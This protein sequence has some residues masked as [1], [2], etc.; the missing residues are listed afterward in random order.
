MAGTLGA[1]RFYA[2]ARHGARA[3]HTRT[4]T[5]RRG[6][7]G[8]ARTGC[9]AAAAPSS[10]AAT[11]AP[12]RASPRGSGAERTR[13]RG[14]GRP[15]AGAPG[16]GF[17]IWGPGSG[18]R[19]GAA[20]ALGAGASAARLLA[21]PPAA[22]APASP[23]ARGPPRCP[24]PPSPALPGEPRASLSSRAPSSANR[25]H[26]E[27][28]SA[29]GP[30]PAAAGRSALGRENGAAGRDG[31][32]GSAPASGWGKHR[33]PLCPQ[34]PRRDAPRKTPLWR[35]SGEGPGAVFSFPTPVPGPDRPA[36][37]CEQRPVPSAV[38]RLSRAGL[39]RIR[40]LR[41]PGCL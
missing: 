28:P 4:H 32:R 7:S 12:R 9:G 24:R 2:C 19:S 40:R 6:G 22:R 27:P 14:P 39:I 5:A 41:P 36:P 26:R 15:G 3:R 23:A 11:T 37:L 34:Q 30:L 29:A 31:A 21:R 35:P 13:P 10:G 17:R 33:R 38:R 20:A 16:P 1:T 8:A 18:S 25:P